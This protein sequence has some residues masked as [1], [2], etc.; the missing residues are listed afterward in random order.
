MPHYHASQAEDFNIDNAYQPS[1]P[2][3]DI[4]MPSFSD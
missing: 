2:G 3:F 1:I 4:L